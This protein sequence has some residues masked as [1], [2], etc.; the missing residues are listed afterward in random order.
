MPDEDND[1]YEERLDQAAEDMVDS[2]KSL[3]DAS[4]EFG[5]DRDDLSRRFGEEMEERYGQ[6]GE[7]DEDDE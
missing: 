2:G 5:V 6:D 1:Q 3:H 4:E 7:D